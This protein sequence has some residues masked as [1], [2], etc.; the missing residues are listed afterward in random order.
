LELAETGRE[1]RRLRSGGS[2]PAAQVRRLRARGPVPPVA[3]GV[4]F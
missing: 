3:G 1:V 4:P 2:G